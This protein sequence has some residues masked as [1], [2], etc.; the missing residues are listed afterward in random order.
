M[1]AKRARSAAPEARNR[2]AGAVDCVRR[3]V[4]ALGQSARAVEQRTG[5]T[6]A[7]LFLLRQLD[8]DGTLTINELAERALSQ[9]S[10]VS[11]LVRRLEEAGHVTRRPSED[12][13]RRVCVTMTAAGKNVVRRAPKPPLAQM[14]DALDRL[15]PSEVDSLTRGL[16]SLLRE[17]HAPAVKTPLFESRSRR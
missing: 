1:A 17:M 2:T 3:L 5:L 11:L 7:Q 10:T 4:N 9:Q 8:H 15:P 12:D 6:N 14:I 13:G 16:G